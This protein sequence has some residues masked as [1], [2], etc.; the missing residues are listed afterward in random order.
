MELRRLLS[1]K[2]TPESPQRTK[3]PC[4]RSRWRL[5][6]ALAI[7]ALVACDIQPVAVGTWQ[8]QVGDGQDTRQEIWTISDAGQIT[9]ARDSGSITT[10]VELAG[11]RVSWTTGS[12]EPTA[13]DRVNF[14]GTVNGNELSGTLFSQQG[15]R[16]VTG[17]RR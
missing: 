7:G 11:S 10:A 1:L 17:T 9:L 8:V 3:S 14:S 15:N 13:S 5:L 4:P 16:T 12:M 2:S 6:I